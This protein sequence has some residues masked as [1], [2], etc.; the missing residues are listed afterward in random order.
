MTRRKAGGYAH[1]RLLSDA[2]RA[3]ERARKLLRRA[4]DAHSAQAQAAMLC[5]CALE[6]AAVNDALAEM[7]VLLCGSEP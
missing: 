3:N 2:K 4:V 6:M 5:A 1:R 7:Q